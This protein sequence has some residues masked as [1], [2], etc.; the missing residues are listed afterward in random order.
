MSLAHPVG[1]KPF[2]P[3]LVGRLVYGALLPMCVATEGLRRLASRMSSEAEDAR[4]AP[5]SWFAE[6][7]CGAKIAASYVQLARHEL[8]SSERRPRPVRPS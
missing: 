3:G 6:A 7:C 8:K 1:V 5:P 4:P 2:A